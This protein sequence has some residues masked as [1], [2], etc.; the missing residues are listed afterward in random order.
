MT[1]VN[2][3]SK[4][5]IPSGNSRENNIKRASESPENMKDESLMKVCKDFEALFVHMMLKSMRAT[6]PD[7]GLIP[8]STAT[9]MFEDMHDQE[10]ASAIAN[11][12]NGFGIAQMLYDQMKSSLAYKQ[13]L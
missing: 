12:G 8:K 11:N 10:M 1:I 6:V 2:G 3:F 13:N 7:N 5:M 4:T 9:E